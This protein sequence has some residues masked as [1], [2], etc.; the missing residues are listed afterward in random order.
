MAEEQEELLDEVEIDESAPKKKSPVKMIIILL[1]VLGLLGGGGYFAYMKY[2]QPGQST[3]AV[4]EGESVEEAS[5]SLGIMFSLDPF[6]VNLAGSQG[7]RFLKVTVAL[8][9]SAPEVHAE[10]KENIQKIMDSIL[11][12]LSS[13]NFEDVYSV[14]GKF[15]LKDEI[16]ARVNRFLILGHIKEAYFT[17]F[18]IQ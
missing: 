5:P 15:K 17:E 6:I 3:E 16:T 4:G 14:Q 9:L 11:V 1:V 13:K 2:M 18:I 8:E 10:V 12:L 7:K